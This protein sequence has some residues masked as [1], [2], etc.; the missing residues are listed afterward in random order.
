MKKKIKGWWGVWIIPAGLGAGVMGLA[1]QGAITVPGP[2][3][4]ATRRLPIL[5]V[6]APR[7]AVVEAPATPAAHPAVLR[8]SPAAL[9]ANGEPSRV[10]PRVILLLKD[11]SKLLGCLDTNTLAFKTAL[12]GDVSIPL[13]RVRT[14][15]WP[16]G[17]TNAVLTFMNGD[18][19]N[20]RPSGS[21]MHLK[22][23]FGEW[24]I[25][26]PMVTQLQVDASSI[27]GSAAVAV[28]HRWSGEE[29]ARDSEGN[30]HGRLVNG[31]TFAPGISGKA[32]NFD[33]RDAAVEFPEE[34][35]NFG[36]ND[37]TISFW[38]RPQADS[39]ALLSKRPAANC[40]HLVFWDIRG[41]KTGLGFGAHSGSGDWV[42]LPC[43]ARIED[44][45]FHHVAIARQATTF[46]L[47]LDGVVKK[48][49]NSA[50]LLN[51]ADH[52]PLRLGAN[53]CI[54]VDGTLPFKGQVDEILLYDRALCAAEV[55]SLFLEQR[56][57]PE[58][59]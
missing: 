31:V 5:A 9:A 12:T 54:G 1:T 17:E 14:M 58:K 41:G 18:Q 51:L 52:T 29:D 44:A 21:G 48:S 2:P 39:C 10:S 57:K 40:D 3:E 20:G 22:T 47:Y 26:W 42:H 24:K 50:G 7:D 15:R 25:S 53:P 16:A 35:G 55:E 34:S 37:F 27:P 36:T 32:F 43:E 19:L 30:A 49:A 33:G 13:A 8:P 38:M 56:A 28:V 4:G 59:Q 11:G 46:T 6:P 45:E 23:I